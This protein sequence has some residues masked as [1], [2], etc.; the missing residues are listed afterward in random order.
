MDKLSRAASLDM[1]FSSLNESSLEQDVFFAARAGETEALGAMIQADP[2]VANL[3]ISCYEGHD[4]YGTMKRF[5]GVRC[6]TFT[7]VEKDGFTFP[8]HVAAESGHKDLVHFLVEKGADIDAEDYRGQIPEEKANGSAKDAFLELRGFTFE[9]HDRY[10]GDTNAQGE[11]HGN[12]IMFTKCQGFD[13]EEHICYEGHFEKGVYSGQGVLYHRPAKK[14]ARRTDLSVVSMRASDTDARPARAY[15]GTFANG[16]KHGRGT[17]YNEAGF[18]VYVGIFRK[19]LRHGHGISFEVRNS[20]I[21]GESE[22]PIYEGSWRDGIQHGYGVAYLSDGHRFEGSFVRGDMSGAGTYY[23]PNGDRFEGMFEEN[24]PNG[25][26]SYYHTDGSR[27]DGHWEGGN[28]AQKGGRQFLPEPDDLGF[29]NEEVASDSGSEGEGGDPSEEVILQDAFNGL[30]SYV[31]QLRWLGDNPYLQ[32]AADYY[33]GVMKV[34]ERRMSSG[35]LSTYP[36]EFIALQQAVNGAINDL[37][38]FYKSQRRGLQAVRAAQLAQLQ[39][40]RPSTADLPLPV[41]SSSRRRSSLAVSTRRGSLASLVSNSTA[42]SPSLSMA[43]IPRPPPAAAADAGTGTG[44]SGASAY[45]A[46]P[47][48]PADE[49]DLASRVARR[50]LEVVVELHWALHEDK[51][52][53]YAKDL[54]TSLRQA[55]V[56]RGLDL[57]RG[58]E[59]D[60]DRP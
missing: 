41:V 59:C 55:A 39:L 28:I 27:V 44:G 19:G 34:V 26:G 51:T 20:I 7:G 32:I 9:A 50:E 60:R 52:N 12:G 2:A 57:M 54:A 1:D 18:K 4:V 3:A 33:D 8:L 13:E 47:E 16:L 56:V 23:H 29:A 46:H 48:G 45:A 15:M 6:Y 36:P 11:P 31:R 5:N 10:E 53:V 24:K 17:E 38:V 21:G 30:G 25:R 58:V 42:R 14:K 49:S 40:E 35:H 43:S 37:V 22:A